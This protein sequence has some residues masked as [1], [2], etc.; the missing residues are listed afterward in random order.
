MASP[1]NLWRVAA[2]MTK[3]SRTADK[4]WSSTWGLGEVL[5][6]PHRKNVSCYKL[7]IK[8]TSELDGYSG[9]A[10]ATEKR[11]EI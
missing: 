3:Q 4:G 10:L 8:K 2:N 1:P 11:H 7:F 6:T 9:T 5:K